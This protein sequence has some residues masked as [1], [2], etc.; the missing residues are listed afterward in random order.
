VVEAAVAAVAVLL[1]QAMQM[2]S[3]PIPSRMVNANRLVTG[4]ERFV[5]PM[6][7]VR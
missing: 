7:G 3:L 2:G 6:N 1:V 5:L 4:N